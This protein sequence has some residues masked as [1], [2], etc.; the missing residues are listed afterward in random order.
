MNPE[1]RWI[2][3]AAVIPWFA[4]EDR[5]DRL[6]P[7]KIGMSAKP[8]R[9][10]LGSLIIQKQ[11]GYSDQE[12]V[13]QSTENPYY[14]YFIGLAGY[15]QEAPFVLSLLIEFRKR[16]T[17]DILSEINKMIIEFNQPNEETLSGGSN[18]GSEN[19]DSTAFKGTE[20]KG[21]L[22]LDATCTPQNIAYSPDINLLNEARDDRCGM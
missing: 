14:Q 6:F 16:L 18:S 17:D 13:E 19:E 10:A 1:N 9:M 20:N 5:Y 2:K 8:L 15:Q 22:M 4:I 7:A 11:Y 21:T 3:K 12:L